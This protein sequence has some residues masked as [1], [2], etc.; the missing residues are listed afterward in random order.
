MELKVYIPGKRFPSV[1]VT[2]TACHLN[3]AHCGRHYLKGMVDGSRS[4][5][6]VCLKPG[7]NGCLI[8]GGLDGR[9]KV[10]IDRHAEELKELKKMGLK[11]NAHVGFIDESDI[12]WLRYVDVVSLDFVG[13]DE[14]IRR[15]YGIKKRVRDYIE[16][17]ELL[18]SE[19]IR[20]APHLTIGLDF[21]RVWWEKEAVE[22]L[23]SY[24][25]KI[26]ILVLDA[27]IP[28]KGTDM[29]NAGVKEPSIVES[30]EVLGYAR[31]LFR[32]EL[33]VGCMR[34]RGKWRKEFDRKAIK[35]GINRITNPPRDAIEFAKELG[36]RIR[37]IEECCVM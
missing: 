32:G 4:L 30:M 2:G 3:C 31:E 26:D 7:I 17:I 22:T 12:E 37:I 14:V 27:L 20:V 33:S 10:P 28:T 23:S 5:K 13:S 21:G 18:T 29:W 15:V 6:N 24:W 16:V 8:S 1:S 35:E 11:I 9:L 19:G 36:M 25:P 34:P